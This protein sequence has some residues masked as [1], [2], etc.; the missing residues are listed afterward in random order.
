MTTTITYT[1]SQIRDFAQALADNETVDLPNGQTLRLRRDYD[2]LVTINDFDYLGKVEPVQPD[3]YYGCYPHAERPRGFDGSARIMRTR[4]GNYWWQPPDGFAT[5]EKD[6][7]R[8]IWRTACDVVEY[9]YYVY[10]VELCED[11]DAYRR[12]IVREVEFLG[13]IE[14]NLSHN[15]EVS[16]I[17]EVLGLLFA[18]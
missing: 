2:H 17:E 5:Y 6:V 3:R 18:R 16:T 7:Q 15:D 9:G 12:P 1:H 4:Y 10:I 11:Q 14:P 13:G 8:A